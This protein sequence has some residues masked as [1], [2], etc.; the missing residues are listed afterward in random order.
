MGYMPWQSWGHFWDKWGKIFALSTN[1][2]NPYR[3]IFFFFNE[4]GW[5]LQNES[6]D[7]RVG[8]QQ[9]EEKEA[10]SKL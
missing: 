8:S 2:E 4:Y 7:E 1:S 5:E 3:G 10:L 9:E 6:Q